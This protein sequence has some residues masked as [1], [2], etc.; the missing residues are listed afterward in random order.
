M[1]ARRSVYSHLVVTESGP[2]VNGGG[3]VRSLCPGV[4]YNAKVGRQ[5]PGPILIA[6]APLPRGSTRLQ[7]GEARESTVPDEIP[8]QARDSTDPDENPPPG[9]VSTTCTRLHRP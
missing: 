5:S 1:R 3:R 4:Q 2:Y 9:R 8:P 7:N 6:A